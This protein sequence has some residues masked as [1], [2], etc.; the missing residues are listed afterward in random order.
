VHT[1]SCNADQRKGPRQALDRNGVN[2][3]AGGT[4]HQYSRILT[5]KSGNPGLTDPAFGTQPAFLSHSIILSSL[6]DLDSEQNRGVT[7]LTM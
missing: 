4:D 3:I 5:P 6:E 1:T 7:Y 2:K